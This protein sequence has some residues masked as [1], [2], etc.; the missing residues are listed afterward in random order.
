MKNLSGINNQSI[1]QLRNKLNVLLANFQMHYQNLRAFHWNVSG[2]HFFELHAKFEELYNDANQ[3]VDEIAERIL[4]LNGKPAHTFS[5][6]LKTAKIG[7]ADDKKSAEEMVA[8]VL[9]NF[10]VLLEL[11]REILTLAADAGD[12]GTV[13]LI[14]DYVK[15]QEKTGWMLNAYLN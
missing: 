5:E 10:Y 6:Y 2:K 13:T 4:T 9:E 7:E 14:S 11:E 15:E 3:A 8:G 1:E 12:E